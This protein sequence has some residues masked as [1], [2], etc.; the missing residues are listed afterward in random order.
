VCRNVYE[1]VCMRCIYWEGLGWV[2][3]CVCEGGGGICAGIAYQHLC[4]LYVLSGYLLLFIYNLLMGLYIFFFSF[5]TDTCPFFL[6]MIV[7]FEALCKCIIYLFHFFTVGIIVSASL[8][9]VCKRI[10]VF[11]LAVIVVM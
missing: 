1:S 3:F 4:I 11:V 8:L 6:H 9:S 7:W 10:C 2:L 5:L